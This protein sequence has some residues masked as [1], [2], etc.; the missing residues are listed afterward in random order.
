MENNSE[1]K[2][3]RPG[4]GKKYTDENNTETS[5]NFHDGKPIF[6]DIKKGWTCCNKLVYDWA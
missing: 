1:K 6:H 4:C 5:C 2:C 3:F